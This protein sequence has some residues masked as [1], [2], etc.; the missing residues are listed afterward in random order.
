MLPS[1]SINP[2]PGDRPFPGS[3]RRPVSTKAAGARPG[4]GNR[5]GVGVGQCRTPPKSAVK[6]KSNPPASSWVPCPVGGPACPHPTALS[7]IRPLAG[8]LG[9][10]GAEPGPLLPRVVSRKGGAGV[11]GCMGGARLSAAPT[12]LQRTRRR[13]LPGHRLLGGPGPC[14]PSPAMGQGRPL[15]GGP[16]LGAQLALPFPAS[17]PTAGVQAPTIRGHSPPHPCPTAGAGGVGPGWAGILLDFESCALMV[18]CPTQPLHFRGERGA[19]GVYL[20]H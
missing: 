18:P 2:L 9:G 20:P 11:V 5:R 16:T 17:R 6:R 7:S 14:R 13:V 10:L 3:R 8:G 12:T 15:L 1:P 4:S 19:A